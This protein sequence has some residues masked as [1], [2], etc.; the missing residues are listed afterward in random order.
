M[1]TDENNYFNIKN[2]N[3]DVNLEN[4]SVTYFVVYLGYKCMKKFNCSYC[5]CDLFTDK[6]LNN[7]KQLLLI[8]KNYTLIDNENGLKTPSNYFNNVIN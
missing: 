6:N 1:S 4:C 8:N 7:E 3:N 5:Q 2:V